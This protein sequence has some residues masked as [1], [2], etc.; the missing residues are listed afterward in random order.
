VVWGWDEHR[1]SQTCFFFQ[2]I[3]N[4]VEIEEALEP[5]AKTMLL[6]ICFTLW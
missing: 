2:K 6:S 3:S 4:N 5:D 1:F